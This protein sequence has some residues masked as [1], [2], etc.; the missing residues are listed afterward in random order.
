MIITIYNII[1]RKRIFIF[2]S[3]TLWDMSLDIRDISLELG[4][5]AID[6]YRYNYLP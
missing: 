6:T 3:I 1:F 5:K 4:V 2:G